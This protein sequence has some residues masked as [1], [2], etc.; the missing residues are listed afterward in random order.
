MEEIIKLGDDIFECY[1][2]P[3]ID[4][5]YH[6]LMNTE[7]PYKALLNNITSLVESKKLIKI[8]NEGE[9]NVEYYMRIHDVK[10]ED[11][12]TNPIICILTYRPHEMILSYKIS[13]EKKITRPDKK[14]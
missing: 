5:N 13:F 8:T 4:K 14:L 6:F 3:D 7:L 1:I 9:N 11:N 2:S 12:N 10:I